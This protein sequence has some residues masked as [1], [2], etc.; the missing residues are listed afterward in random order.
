MK[1]LKDKIAYELWVALNQHSSIF[2]CKTSWHLHRKIEI[3]WDMLDEIDKMI[4][5]EKNLDM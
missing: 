4:K 5:K 2:E 3:L 1:E